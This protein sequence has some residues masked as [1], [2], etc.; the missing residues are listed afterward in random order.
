[1]GKETT[2]ERKQLAP[3]IAAYIKECAAKMGDQNAV[4]A[5]IKHTDWGGRINGKWKWSSSEITVGY[6]KY[7]IKDREVTDE[8][9]LDVMKN[10]L[11]E[12]QVRGKVFTEPYYPGNFTKV[13]RF[14]RLTI[15]APPCQEFVRLRNLLKVHSG[16]TLPDDAVY[17][18]AVCGKRS[19]YS[20]SGSYR[21]L[22]YNPKNCQ[23]IT[24][25]IEAVSGGKD[26]LRFTVEDFLDHGD[27]G[28]YRSAMYQE[29]EWYGSRGSNLHI[30][31]TDSGGKEKF[32]DVCSYNYCPPIPEHLAGRKPTEDEVL[33]I[34]KACIKD[35]S[36]REFSGD[37]KEVLKEFFG[38]LD[39]AKAWF[40][41]HEAEFM[42]LDVPQQW[43]DGVR[44]SLDSIFDGRQRNMMHIR[45]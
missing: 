1:M 40:R 5:A 13:D 3:V 35:T 4:D 41:T 20:D 22:C 14:S 32:N 7:I 18:V 45:I 30:T 16:R 23:R 10:A 12:S 27:E 38:T 33:R 6:D 19:S 26:K 34:M 43:I 31:V 21:Y 28:D 15:F 2:I 29:R 37:Q 8:Y 39:A 9:F 25:L 11:K 42:K 24:D 44:D 36:F 17:D